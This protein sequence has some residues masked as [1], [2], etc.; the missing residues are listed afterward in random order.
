VASAGPHRH[1]HIN[2]TSLQ[3]NNH[4]STSSLNSYRPDALP[5]AQTTVAKHWRQHTHGVHKIMNC[6]PPICLASE[7]RQTRASAE[8]INT[9]IL[10]LQ[11]VHATALHD[12][13]DVLHMHYHH[14]FLLTQRY[15]SAVYTMVLRLSVCHQ[16]VFSWNSWKDQAGLWHRV[17]PR[18]CV[19]REF[20]H[21]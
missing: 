13:G 14:H 21:I 11:P 4:T 20:G 9:G 12:D 1:T 19:L 18:L 5:A 8:N 16:S 10:R 3:T 7:L 6:S 2:C 17:Y 15:D